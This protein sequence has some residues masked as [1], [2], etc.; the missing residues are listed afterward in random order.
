MFRELR[1]GR[2]YR[3]TFSEARCL[4]VG[5]G[6]VVTFVAWRPD[7]AHPSA[8]WHARAVW[9]NGVEIGP[10]SVLWRAEPAPSCHHDPETWC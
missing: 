9:G 7:P 10:R 2:R 8:R 3:V 5:V 4:G 1:P 6:L